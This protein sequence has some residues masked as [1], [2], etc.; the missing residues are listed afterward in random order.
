MSLSDAM[1]VILDRARANPAP[2]YP[3]MPIND[4][5]ATF[6]KLT[7]YWNQKPQPVFKVEDLLIQ[8]AA[9]ALPALH[10][11]STTAMGRPPMA[12]MSLRL[13]ITAL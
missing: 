3:S 12:A 6:L 4:A 1:R 5:R 7:S 10:I 2:D 9:C 13:T 8:T 11:A